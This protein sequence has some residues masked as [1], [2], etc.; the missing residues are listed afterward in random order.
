LLLVAL[1][2]QESKQTVDSGNTFENA[3]DKR[4]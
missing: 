4:H 1:C 2:F 3:S